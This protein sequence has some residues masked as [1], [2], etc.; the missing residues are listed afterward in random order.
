[1]QVSDDDREWVIN[2][3]PGLTFTT[4]T[5]GLELNGKFCFDTAWDESRRVYLIN[6][7]ANESQGL[8]RIQDSYRIRAV[9]PP[10][11]L[12]PRLFETGGR[13]LAKASNLG[14]PPRDV[15]SY[16]TGQVCPIGQFDMEGI[17]DIREFLDRAALQ[18]FYDQSYHE[19][20]GRWPR[21]QYLHGLFGA[22][23]NYYDQVEEK[24]K[25]LACKLLHDIFDEKRSDDEVVLIRGIL[26]N[27]Q[28]IQGHWPCLCGSG[29][30]FR[31]CHVTLFHG[32]WSLQENLRQYPV[33]KN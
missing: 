5:D 33:S 17:R 32:L 29:R 28:R 20:Y 6:P 1:M 31:S 3:Y 21:G 10:D 18:F 19:R 24:M 13:I 2:Q 9:I 7:T 30:N 12:A 27:K 16:E 22:V 14:V 15:H 26:M 8:V 11:S 4:G 25:A 23:E